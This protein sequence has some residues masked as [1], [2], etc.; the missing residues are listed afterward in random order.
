MV[1]VKIPF[2]IRKLKLSG[3]LRKY[4]SLICAVNIFSALYPI[5][6]LLD[7]QTYF[8]TDQPF[9]RTV[10]CSHFNV[11]ISHKYMYL[12]CTLSVRIAFVKDQLSYSIICNFCI[13]FKICKFS[14]I[15]LLHK[16]LTRDA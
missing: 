10:A 11:I 8:S 6:F 16:I 4:F 12:K 1:P 7:E 15:D 9:Y 2:K 3:I 5:I 13:Y 14:N